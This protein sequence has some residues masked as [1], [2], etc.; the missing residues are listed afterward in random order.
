MP[1]TKEAVDVQMGA[2]T[3]TFQVADANTG[4]LKPKVI[5][6][7]R[8]LDE[9]KQILVKEKWF[10]DK[11]HS[12][13]QVR[14]LGLCPIRFEDKTDQSGNPTGD[15]AKIPAFWIYFPESRKIM[16]N[17]EIFNRFNDAQHISF[18]DFFFQRRFSSYIYRE[19]NVYD[20]RNVSDYASG[21]EALYESDKIKE[22]L[23]N[24]EHDL[25]EY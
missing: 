4:E 14:I 16:A 20:N 1:L 10:F 7:D 22:S 17:H 21:V 15:I 6:K 19:S 5:T 25:W 18:D 12:T 11:Q 2:K 3:D 13:M 8:Q 9:V 24:I 23:F